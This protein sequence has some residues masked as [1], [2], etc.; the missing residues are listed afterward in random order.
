MSNNCP[1]Q[2]PCH[3]GDQNNR[4]RLVDYTDGDILTDECHVDPSATRW[5]G[6]FATRVAPCKWNSCEGNY[7]LN[8]D[9]MLCEPGTC[10]YFAPAEPSGKWGIRVCGY[11]PDGA[12]LLLWEGEK[13]TGDDPEGSYGK[14]GGTS[15]GPP[16]LELERY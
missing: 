1:S 2:C 10:V 16:H 12:E 9:H 8:G 7:K 15:P 13:G 6:T 3:F 4:F 5:E 11:S 14:T